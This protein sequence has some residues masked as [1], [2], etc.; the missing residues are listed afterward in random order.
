M[1]S[2]CS[3]ELGAEGPKRR[4][5][6]GK[7]HDE[8]EREKKRKQEKEEERGKQ[9]QEEKKDRQEKEEERDKQVKREREGRTERTEKGTEKTGQGKE[10]EDDDVAHRQSNK[11][12]SAA[13]LCFAN[14]DS[15]PDGRREGFESL[16]ARSRARAAAAATAAEGGA[17]PTDGRP[18]APTPID[19]SGVS[20]PPPP[21]QEEPSDAQPPPAQPAT[22]ASAA[23]ADSQFP[24]PPRKKP[25]TS[26]QEIE[27]IQQQLSGLQLAP[28]VLARLPSA[29]RKLSV[30][31]WMDILDRVRP[32]PR[33]PVCGLTVF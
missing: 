20:F 14:A 12:Q 26:A 30:E 25:R 27:L 2:N 8:E 19:W 7:D 15:E 13:G 28:R 32:P 31:T 33:P 1:S 9:E 18:S 17:V 24:P 3:G 11:P 4:K 5:V 6:K 23:A 29:F 22:G 16:V 21:P 10:E